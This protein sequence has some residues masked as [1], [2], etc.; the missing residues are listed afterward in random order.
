MNVYY[1]KGTASVSFKN[2]DAR[3]KPAWDLCDYDKGILR[4]RYTVKNSKEC[5][6]DV[7]VKILPEDIFFVSGIQSKGMEIL[8][9]S[10]LTK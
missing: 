6:F 8:Y 1:V 9:K 3:F 5:P 10:R 2:A 7:N 4:L